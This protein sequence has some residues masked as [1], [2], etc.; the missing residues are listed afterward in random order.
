VGMGSLGAHR[1]KGEALSEIKDGVYGSVAG[2]V[3][4]VGQAKNGPYAVIEV[5]R[6]GAKYP[7]RVTA[8]GLEAAVGDRVSVKGWLSWRREE[9]DG[10]TYLNVSL[11]Q[12]KV[13]KHERAG[14]SS[15]IP[16]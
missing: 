11:N 6:D 5:A 10:K 3:G 15:E 16:F 7:D 9:K 4:R 2:T 12:P 13:D 1:M 8:W 14:G